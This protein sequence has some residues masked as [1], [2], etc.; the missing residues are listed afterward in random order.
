M[1]KSFVVPRGIERRRAEGMETVILSRGALKEILITVRPDDG[2]DLQALLEKAWAVVRAEGA[3]VLRQEVFGVASIPDEVERS[4]LRDVCGEVDWP[5]TWLDEGKSPG[6]RLTGTHVHAVSGVPVRRL[7]LDGDAVGSVFSDGVAE[8]G[9][10]GGI[11]SLNP[12]VDRKRQTR[13]VLERIEAA[14]AL[15]GMTFGNIVRTWFYLD[16]ILDWYDDFNA[17]RTQFFTERGVF[18]GLVPASTGVGGGNRHGAALVA[19]ALAVRAL[20]GHEN[21]L[22]VKEVSSPLQCPA[23]TYRSSFSRAVEITC[24]GHRRLTISGTAS[25]APEGQTARIGDVA[26]QMDLT[27]DVVQALLESRGLSWRDASRA[28]A[29]VKAEGDAVIFRERAESRGLPPFPLLFA[30]NDIC[31]T[32]LL[33]ELELDAL[34]LNSA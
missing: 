11:A 8:Y 24:Q 12:G 30:E 25:I 34:S 21:E 27:L 19:E 4:A 22:R 18:D 7:A 31:R 6:A 26:G 5:V 17:V 16:H 20:P 10:L 2:M 3:T 32:D 1:K 23:T 29:Y 15:A 13:D 28:I 14:A 33:F 9:H